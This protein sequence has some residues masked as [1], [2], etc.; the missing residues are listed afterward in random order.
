M[1]GKLSTIRKRYMR[2]YFSIA[3]C[4]AQLPIF[5][6]ISVK[7]PEKLSEQPKTIGF[8]LSY[9][10][11]D[12]GDTVPVVNLHAVSVIEDRIFASKREERKWSRLKRDVA[13]VYPYSKVAGKKLK[14][15][16]DMMVGK[17]DKEQKRI[18]RQAEADIK[19]QFEGD[20]RNMT[21]NQGRILI[22]LIDRETGNTSYA[23]VKDLRGSFQAVFWQS[24]ARIFG[25]NLKSGYDPKKDPEDKMIEEIIHTIEEGTFVN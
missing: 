4:L 6:Q 24:I 19:K 15:Y 12:E 21:M 1:A 25:S 22:K 10:V 8:K 20:V 9:F 14:E 23:L 13:K 11:T 5:S 3:F 2:Y 16:N 17:S 18:L 7:T